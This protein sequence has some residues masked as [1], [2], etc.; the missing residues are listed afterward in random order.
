[1]PVFTLN[2][3]HMPKNLFLV[4]FATGILFHAPVLSQ[5]GASLKGALAKQKEGKH[6][7]AIA[8][9]TEIIAGHTA[10]VQAYISTWDEV[11]KW[12]DAERAEKG[13]KFPSL[14][15]TYAKPYLVRGI[16]YAAML[17]NDKAFNDFEIAVKITPLSARAYYERGKIQFLLGKK[18]EGCSDLGTAKV[19]G[20][21]L[22]K[23]LY[24]ERFC[25]SE[26]ITYYKD[27]MSKLRLNQSEAALDF[28]Q[29]AIQICPD[30]ATFYAV[31]GKCYLGM[32]KPDLAFPDLDKTITALPDHKEALYTRG[33]AFYNTGK[34]QAAF[35]DFDR[36][37]S[38]NAKFSDAYLYRAYACE[39]LNMAESAL[40]DYQNVQ[41]LKPRDPVAFYRSGLLKEAKG[42][43][44]GACLEFKKAASMDHAEAA[45]KAKTCK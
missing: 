26:A 39:G 43:V 7:Q 27:A 3:F 21:S 36:V 5:N 42:D 18:F 14:D 31:R 20:D 38:L 2:S 9:L 4:L 29:K 24:E 28:I 10:E 33:V 16:S 25:W 45:E 15:S 12:S 35:D 41:R 34:Y 13:L 8:D 44:K 6:E 30:S 17:K 22:A 19:L 23:D 37:I 11:A 1:M 40:F 32:G